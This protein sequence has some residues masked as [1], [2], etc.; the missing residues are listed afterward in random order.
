MSV[1]RTKKFISLLH[2]FPAW[3]RKLIGISLIFLG[4]LGFLPII[5]F[6]MIPLGLIVL[7]ADYRFARSIYVRSR[8]LIHRFKK[9]RRRA[10]R[11][12]TS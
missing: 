1:S 5:G 2:S 10:A 4:F 7:S 3:L 6:W 12:R 9:K 8:L 11:A